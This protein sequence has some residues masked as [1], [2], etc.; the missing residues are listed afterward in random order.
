MHRKYRAVISD[1]R[2]DN[3]RLVPRLSETAAELD[4]RGIACCL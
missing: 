2:E 4:G 3:R 1:I